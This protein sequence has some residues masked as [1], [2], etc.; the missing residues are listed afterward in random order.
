MLPAK[1][2]R[3]DHHPQVFL[4]K[5]FRS[6]LRTKSKLQSHQEQ[7]HRP[8]SELDHA[9][10]LSSRLANSDLPRQNQ[11]TFKSTLR[12]IPTNPQA[13]SSHLQK[14]HNALSTRL[15]HLRQS[16]DTAQQALQVQSSNQCGE[17][18]SLVQKWRAIAQ[19]VA[20]ELFNDAKERIDT[21]GGLEAWRRR[22]KE[23]AR[24]WNNDDDDEE[25]NQ[26]HEN[27]DRDVQCQEEAEGARVSCDKEQEQEES[28]S[29]GN[30]LPPVRTNLQ[31][32][33]PSPWK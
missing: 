32:R 4:N 24:L 8:D 7:T 16:L 18:Q 6:P 26:Q 28:V 25:D 14:Q 2:R 33:S 13:D 17:L 20:D 23:D 21:M 3:L 9:P 15:T 27:N 5:P 29:R 30:S 1:K 31:S 22:T 10:C 11:P 19:A 12:G